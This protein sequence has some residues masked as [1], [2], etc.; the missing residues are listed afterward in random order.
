MIQPK[1]EIKCR[2]TTVDETDMVENYYAKEDALQQHMATDRYVAKLSV[3]L[4]H[5]MIGTSRNYL[6]VTKLQYPISK[7][8]KST[9]N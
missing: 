3:T 4:D 1:T 9:Q 8:C 7:V 2:Y 5:F 6:F